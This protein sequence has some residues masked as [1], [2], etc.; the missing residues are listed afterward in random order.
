[1]TSI[2]H[3]WMNLV[4]S[5]LPTQLD[6]SRSSPLGSKSALSTLPAVLVVVT[7]SHRWAQANI[8][9]GQAGVE[10]KDVYGSRV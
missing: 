7:P 2:S 3:L 4:D 6:L 1:M 5:S 10:P 9:K 8:R